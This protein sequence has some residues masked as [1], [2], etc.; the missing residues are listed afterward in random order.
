MKETKKCP[1]LLL[2][3][4]LQQP[5]P[6]RPRDAAPLSFLELLRREILGCFC[7]PGWRCRCFQSFSDVQTLRGHR[8]RRCRFP[9]LPL[10]LPLSRPRRRPSSPPIVPPIK[11]SSGSIFA[12][13]RSPDRV[14]WCPSSSS[15]RQ[16]SKRP[17][18]KL[19]PSSASS[20]P[21][22]KP[23]QRLLRPAESRSGCERI[24][25][26]FSFFYFFFCSA[27]LC[28]SSSGIGS[29]PAT[30]RRRR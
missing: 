16:G 15:S 26:S 11:S 24:R 25:L 13:E 1:V 6:Q 19:A 5:L 18:Q 21:A 10:S 27:A 12:Q 17:R 23:A 7:C 29:G 30:Q 3:L 4:F 2:L 28:R 22:R 20:S 8:R 9:V 14:S